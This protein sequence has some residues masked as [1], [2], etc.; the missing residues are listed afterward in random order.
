MLGDFILWLKRVYKQQTCIHD[1]KS[2]ADKSLAGTFDH[3]E[4][5]KCDR[6]KW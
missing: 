3:Y 2:V 6:W 4:C 5:K 1:Y